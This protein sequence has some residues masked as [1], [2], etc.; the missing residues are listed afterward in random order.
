MGSAVLGLET[1]HVVDAIGGELSGSILGR[2][3]S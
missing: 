1:A 2:N 3:H